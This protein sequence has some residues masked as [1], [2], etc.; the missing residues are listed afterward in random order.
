[1]DAF[2]ITSK[3]VLGLS[4]YGLR[5]SFIQEGDDLNSIIVDT[6]KMAK[7]S[8]W[9]RAQNIDCARTYKDNDIIAIKE[10]VLARSQ[11]NYATTDQIIYDL[12]QKFPDDVL[13]VVGSITSRNRFS[14]VL[15]AIAK[16]GFKKVIIQFG[17][18]SDEVGNHFVSMRQVRDAGINPYQDHLTEAQFFGHFGK[19]KHSVTKM[20]YVE[21]YKSF[22]DHIEI[23]FDN[24]INKISK[25]TNQVLGADIHTRVDTKLDLRQAGVERVFGLDNILSSPNHGSGHNEEYGLLGSNKADDGRVK[26][27]PRG[28]QEYVESLQRILF[29]KFG[30]MFQ[31]MIFADG[32]FKC[33]RTKIWEF[34]DPIGAPGF[35]DG[36]AGGPVEIKIKHEVDKLVAK[37]YSRKKIYQDIMKMVLDAA[38]T[39]AFGTTPRMY[40]DLLTSLA[41]LI[42]GSGDKGTPIILI[43][44]YF[45]NYYLR[46][47]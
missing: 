28:C 4:S 17:Y 9:K 38:K 6:L 20:D 7:N 10:S 23:V 31:V 12:R 45:E 37:G 44:R 36:L 39:Q 42:S 21:Y 43:Q 15:E 8:F 3:D 40:V 30:I 5:S 1:M 19:T 22:G 25:M 29:A 32:M 46:A 35:T 47:A 14:P 26:L 24:N 16:A 34:A 13:G 11:G 33:P 2:G 27:F 18:P 41:D